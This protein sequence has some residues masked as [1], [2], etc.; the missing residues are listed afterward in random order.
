MV[1]VLISVTFWRTDVFFFTD[2]LYAKTFRWNV[3]KNYMYRG[4]ATRAVCIDCLWEIFYHCYIVGPFV[5]Y[6]CIMLRTNRDRILN[7][8]PKNSDIRKS[9]CNHLINWTIWIYLWVICPN[10]ADRV[11]NSVEHDDQSDLDLHFLLEW[12]TVRPWSDCPHSVDP[13]PTAL[14]EQSNLGLHCLPR[15]VFW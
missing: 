1:N 6:A 7:K 10:N 4:T 2:R 5:F 15:P 9:C 11:A 12:Q 13:H 3:Q 8:N 14:M